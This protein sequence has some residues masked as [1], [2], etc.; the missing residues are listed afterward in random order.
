MAG[1]RP[2]PGVQLQAIARLRWWLVI[3][4]LR[5]VRGQLNLISRI[6]GGLLVL[7]MGAMG[8]ASLFFVGLWAT[9]HDPSWLATRCCVFR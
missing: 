4:S 3:N 6:L 1:L 8:A 2:Q 7:G 5:S 9:S